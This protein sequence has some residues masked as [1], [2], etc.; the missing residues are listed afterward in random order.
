MSHESI[1][2]NTVNLRSL[3]R[4]VILTEPHPSVELKAATLHLVGDASQHEQYEVLRALENYGWR[5]HA[6]M[7]DSDYEYEVYAPPMSKS[8]ADCL[9]DMEIVHECA[10][11]ALD[12][13]HAEQTLPPLNRQVVAPEELQAKAREMAG[14]VVTRLREDRAEREGLG[15]E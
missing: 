10:Q 14:N 8:I 2:R 11:A 12:G 13:I 6:R 7:R 15:D 3:L 9:V 5:M 1:L 4:R